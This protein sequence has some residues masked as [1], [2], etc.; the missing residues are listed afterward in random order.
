[1]LRPYR[2]LAGVPRLPSLLSW[3]LAG[4]LYIT[5]TGLAVSF[6]IA[7]WTS[8]YAVAGV[9]GGAL[10]LGQGV[11]GPLR[12][13]AADRSSASRLLLF[14]AVGYGLGLAALAV[15][16]HLLGPGNWPVAVV[17]ALVTGL[18]LPPATQIGR[19]VWPRITQ[20]EA[21]EALYT[22]EA[23]LQE[24]MFVIGPVLAASAVAVFGPTAAVL[25]VAV[26]VVLGSC[27]FAASL[28]R[29]G[30]DTPPPPV[31]QVHGV[32]R[33]SLLAERGLLASMALVL[34]LVASL[35]AVDLVMVA[36]ARGLGFPA[37]AGILGAV[38]ATGS[39][40][41]GLIIGGLGG[42]PRLV[43]RLAVVAVGM[44]ALIPVLPP[45]LSP[46]SPWL[47]GAILLVGGTAIAPSFAAANSRLSAL[48]PEDR[49]GE[50][51]G[52]QSTAVTA[53]STLALPLCG[54]LLDHFGPAAGVAGATGFAA[55]A[56]LFA[57]AV[58]SART[59]ITQVTPVKMGG[60]DDTL[61]R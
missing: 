49:R 16:P 43:P 39:T 31:E 7:G 40:I 57:L 36:W 24:L 58:P 56:A 29:A 26:Y 12:G 30:L 20:G 1:M 51:F 34:C 2:Q 53:G 21:R 55:A 9:V 5:G 46:A 45:L 47:V 37:L 10:T 25:G 11:A 14:T 52:W 6:L 27:G 15:L 28:R 50:A 3:S 48:A 4:R 13:R 17:I 22:V 23:T 32:R 44:A 41:G 61:I 38:W 60:V 35:V 59:E 19:A 8:S 42:R 18:F 54:S 33:R